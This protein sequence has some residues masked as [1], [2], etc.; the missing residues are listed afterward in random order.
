MEEACWDDVKRASEMIL[1][2]LGLGQGT[3]DSVNSATVSRWDVSD[4]LSYLLHL[5]DAAVRLI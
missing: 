2:T 3:V 5:V 1:V 4:L